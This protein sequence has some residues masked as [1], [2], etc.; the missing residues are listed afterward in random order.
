MST[1]GR[2]LERIEALA[3]PGE[4]GEASTI[5]LRVLCTAVERHRATVAGGPL[6]AYA[7]EEI[8]HLRESDIEVAAGGGVVAALRESPG[9]QALGAQEVLDGWEHDARRRLA[10]AEELGEEWARAYQEEDDE[11]EGEA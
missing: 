4:R 2:R 1:L 5:E 6:P 8:E 7:S 11:T 3:S 9:W 10:R